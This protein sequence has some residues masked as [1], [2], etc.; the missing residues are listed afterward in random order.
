MAELTVFVLVPNAEDRV[1]RCLKSVAWADDL[2]CVVD[3]KTNDGSQKI[4]E[5]YT[6]HIV[7]HEY[8]N[9]ATQ[10]NWGLAQIQTEWTLVLDA[11]EWVPDE[12]ASRIREI[13][14]DPASLDYYRI[15]RRSYF[16][17]KLIGHGGWEHDYNLRLFRTAKARYQNR[18]VHPKL[19][20]HGAAG[21]IEEPMYHDTHRS[22]EEYFA[23]FHRFTTWGA[24]D[25]YEAG[26]RA[27]TR[28]LLLR[29]LLRFLKMYVLRRGFLDGRHGAVLCGLAS[30]AV[31]TK[32]A[33]LWNLKR[34]SQQ[35]GGMVQL[36]LRE[37]EQQE[38]RA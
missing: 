14:A 33:K 24:E 7:V 26:R 11:D 36:S 4:A 19:Q 34:L 35:P 22:F 31:F 29:P 25:L 28:D 2:F 10:R 12:L 20:I 16:F 30:F 6:D 5:E 21:T 9:F 13:V 8:V 15:K 37:A 18:R 32:Y 17:G 27:R 38:M 23:T 1:R 3:T